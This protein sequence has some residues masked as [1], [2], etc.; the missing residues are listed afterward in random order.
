MSRF[1]IIV[2]AKTGERTEV[3]FTPEE[4]AAADAPR[5]FTAYDTAALNAALTE[6]GSVV[7][8]LGL[9][10]F[11][12]INKLRVKTGDAPYTMNQFLTALRAQIR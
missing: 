2:N 8:A 11:T 7:R 6:P 3:P 5:D 10:T 4:E 1:H 12:E 9:L